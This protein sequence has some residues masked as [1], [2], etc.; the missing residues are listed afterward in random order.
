[1]GSTVTLLQIHKPWFHHICFQI[2][3]SMEIPLTF[4]YWLADVSMTL[5]H[6]QVRHASYLLLKISRLMREP[7]IMIFNFQPSGGKGKVLDQASGILGLHPN[8]AAAEPCAF[9]PVT[10]FWPSVAS[11]VL[12]EV[13]TVVSLWVFPLIHF[14]DS[15]LEWH[16]RLLA[17]PEVTGAVALPLFLYEGQG[18]LL[19]IPV[20]KVHLLTWNLSWSC[21]SLLCLN[22]SED[23]NNFPWILPE[24]ERFHMH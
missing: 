23:K 4:K 17:L 21:K 16:V 12:W 19:P 13:Y 11:S 22:A 1:M 24:G 18:V 5:S 7:L 9:G 10:S 3:R 6:G 8:S 15:K 2:S 20:F 14:F